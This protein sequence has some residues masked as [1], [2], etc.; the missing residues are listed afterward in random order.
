MHNS[1][2]AQTPTP[3]LK[4]SVNGIVT[5]KKS[6][7]PVKRASVSI[8]SKELDFKDKTTTDNDGKYLFSDLSAG[9]YTL[10]VN[11]QGFKN[12]KKK[13]ELAEGENEVVDVQLKKETKDDGGY[14]GG[15]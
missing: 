15:Y 3:I 8:K 6:G 4:G 10:R 9:N 13:I 5:V 14:G 7:K 11:K 1:T 12:A 2:N